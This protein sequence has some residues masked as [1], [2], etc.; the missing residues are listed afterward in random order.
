MAGHTVVASA[1][2]LYKLGRSDA[3]AALTQVLGPP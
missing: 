1:N 3:R 2:I